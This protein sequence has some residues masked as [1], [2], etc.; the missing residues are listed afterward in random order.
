MYQSKEINNRLYKAYGDNV[1][2]LYLMQDREFTRLLVEFT[3]GEL[4][5]T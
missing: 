3:I 4:S 2:I 1:D 5:E